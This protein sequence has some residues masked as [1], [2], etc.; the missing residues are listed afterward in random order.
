MKQVGA[1]RAKKCPTGLGFLWKNPSLAGLLRAAPWAEKTSG[2]PRVML[3]VSGGFQPCSLA[4]PWGRGRGPLGACRGFLGRAGFSFSIV[5]L[6][7]EGYCGSL[8]PTT[9]S[10]PVGLMSVAHLSLGSPRISPEAKRNPGHAEQPH[11]L[12]GP[13]KQPGDAHLG[14]AV[15]KLS[16][17][18]GQV[19]GCA[20]CVNRWLLQALRK[21]VHP[22]P[23]PSVDAGYTN[24][25][26]PFGG[27]AL[28]DNGWLLQVFRNDIC[29][30]PE[31]SAEAGKANAA[32]PSGGLTLGDN[33]WL[34]LVFR[35][36]VRPEPEPSVEAGK[37]NNAAPFG[38]LTLGDN[39]RLLQWFRHDVVPEP[40]PS[41]EAGKT[42]AA[43][44]FG[45]HALGD[46]GW[47]LL[48]FRNDVCP[49]PHPS[50]E[51]GKTNAA[52]PLGGRAFGN[53]GWLLQVFRNDVHPEADQSVAAGRGIAAAP[54][55]GRAFGDIGRLLRVFSTDL[56]PSNDPVG[57]DGTVRSTKV[58]RHQAESHGE[59]AKQSESHHGLF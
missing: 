57:E 8:L 54:R 28:G 43:A 17:R 23:D 45:G 34:L 15:P 20:L 19:R 5:S 40:E 42:N 36:D 16:Q 41:A 33:G 26:A 25:A 10:L 46:T 11:G 13:A 50:G 14:K 31:P 56:Y 4:C 37:A 1:W 48:V 38:G 9:R 59:V 44:P 12:E 52:A 22:E 58:H 18:V 24:A 47:L 27:H 51:A 53:T 6:L 3:G 39:G 55:G 29:P 49:E 21:D 2:R 32:A 35:N 7:G 30:E